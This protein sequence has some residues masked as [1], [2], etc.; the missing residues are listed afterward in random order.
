MRP[1]PGRLLGDVIV[2]LGLLRSRDGRSGCGRGTRHRASD[3]S[4]AARAAPAARSPAR[5]RDRRALRAEVRRPQDR[6]A[7][8]G[9]A[10]HH[11]RDRDAAPRR[12]PDRLQGQR[13]AGRC[14]GRP[15][16]PAR[17]RRH[18]DAHE[19]QRRPR[20]RHAR[21]HGRAADPQRPAR[22]PDRGRGASPRRMRP[23][24]RPRSSRPP[25]TVRRSSSC[26]RSSPRR[27]TRELPTSTSIPTTANC[28]S[29]TAS[30]A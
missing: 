29:A 30:T 16:Q 11:S 19:P 3:G 20:G 27:S 26:A 13:L 24:A 6:G 12:G 23:H 21:R 8:P 7:G 15:A 9:R 28:S 14:D 10:G 1:R 5:H 25:T 22:R 18:R 4:A 2:E 17:D